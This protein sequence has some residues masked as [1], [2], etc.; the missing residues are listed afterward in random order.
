MLKTNKTLKGLSVATV[1]AFAATTFSGAPAFAA[2]PEMVLVSALG[3][4][5]N[6]NTLNDYTEFADLDSDSGTQSLL[7]N[8]SNAMTLK[9]WVD[10]VDSGVPTI[11]LS[12]TDDQEF[13]FSRTTASSNSKADI[14]TA[15]DAVNGAVDT[16][17]AGSVVTGQV[18]IVDGVAN[19]PL[20]DVAG[21]QVVTIWALNL[22]TSDPETVSVDAKLY[23]DRDGSGD[24]ST[25]APADYAG[26]SAAIK[27][28]APGDVSF[29]ADFDGL[30]YGATAVDATITTS[31]ALNLNQIFAFAPTQVTAQ[32][33]SRTWLTA[34]QTVAN[35]ALSSDETANGGFFGDLNLEGAVLTNWHSTVDSIDEATFK[36]QAKITAQEAD[37]ELSAAKYQKITQ[38][39]VADITLDVVSKGNVYETAG[40][41]TLRKDVKTFEISGKAVDADDAGVKGA[42]VTVALSTD[43]SSVASKSTIKAGGKTYTVG[44][45]TDAIEVDVTTDADGK[46]SLS[47]TTSFADTDESIAALVS[48]PSTTGID[49]LGTSI[50][51]EAAVQDDWYVSPASADGI[52]NGVAGVT[53]SGT[54]SIDVLAVDQF[55]EGISSVDGEALKVYATDD[56]SAETAITQTK[57]LSSGKATIS[58]KN[59]EAAGSDY[60]IDV[61]LYIEGNSRTVDTEENTTIDVYVWSAASAVVALDADGEFLEGTVTYEDY[62]TGLNVPLGNV[63]EELDVLDSE[64]IEGYIEDATGN[65]QPGAAVTLTGTGYLFNSVDGLTWSKDSIT[66]TADSSGKFEVDIY[67]HLVANKAK[68]T[69]TSGTATE[70]AL[71]SFELPELIDAS[72][73]SWTVS[74]PTYAQTGKTAV[75]TAKLADKWGNGL[76]GQAVDVSLDGVGS[77]N[78][79]YEFTRDTNSKGEVKGYL[80]ANAADLG[81]S[82][83]TFTLTADDEYFDVSAAEDADDITA[84]LD[85]TTKF[86]VTYVKVSGTSKKV[87]VKTA[88]AKGKR[89]KIYVDGVLRY[90]VLKT[91]DTPKTVSFKAPAGKHKV[92]VKVDDVATE[93]VSSKS[94]TVTVTK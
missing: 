16:A 39:K 44:T 88:W 73:V 46:Y 9:V 84:S 70:T 25:S 8:M 40:N 12:G 78:G 52:A 30:A 57:S 1:L 33:T 94:R 20:K 5:S 81:Y 62:A 63:T 2:A 93:S 56:S 55:G 65:V 80:T 43:D 58:F 17:D 54:V 24:L 36:I 50:D 64:T 90:N 92:V 28:I 22:T 38:P 87:N 31:P 49:E 66:V 69:V 21:Y 13:Y 91:I 23:I 26:P 51:W 74:G 35:L 47:V 7:R 79:D 60:E 27:Y 6:F 18:E 11:Q 45:S 71:V 29:S 14:K 37:D 75:L 59:A 48:V 89:V 53:S 15:V 19:F 3:S 86:G 61:Y 10:S 85:L 67:S 41:F 83:V 34:G 72:N 68:V 77:L 32:V 42:V 82:T 4:Q 76:A